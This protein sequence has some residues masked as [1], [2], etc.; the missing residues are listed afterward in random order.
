MTTEVVCHFNM[1]VRISAG[2]FKLV[3]ISAAVT[4][5]DQYCRAFLSWYNICSRNPNHGECKL[6]VYC[7]LKLERRDM[8]TGAYLNPQPVPPRT[9]AVTRM[10]PAID[11]MMRFVAL[12]PVWASV[13]KWDMSS[14]SL[15]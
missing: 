12:G 7:C 11:P 15:L 2:P 6:Q 5:A 1:Q 4:L 3:S 8:Q 14:D 13:G 10:A 9:I